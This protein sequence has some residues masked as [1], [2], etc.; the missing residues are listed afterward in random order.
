MSERDASPFCTGLAAEAKRDPEAIDRLFAALTEV[1]ANLTRAGRVYGGGLNK[2]EPKELEAI[3]LPAWAR[4]RYGQL[5]KRKAVQR[6][7][8]TASRIAQ[9][10]R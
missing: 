9:V 5:C 1:A 3:E 7:L 6:G 8:F 10:G 4:E 2:I